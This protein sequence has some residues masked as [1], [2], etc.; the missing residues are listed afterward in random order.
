MTKNVSSFFGKFHWKMYTTTMLIII[1]QIIH[2]VQVVSTDT[3]NDLRCVF[4]VFLF[5][6]YVF[7][8]I[9]I[10]C[11]GLSCLI[12]SIMPLTFLYC[13]LFKYIVVRVS[14]IFFVGIAICCYSDNYYYYMLSAVPQLL[15]FLP[16]MYVCL[17][18]LVVDNI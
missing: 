16:N 10:F 12:H 1:S 5:V 14:L 15:I 11:F 4:D 7:N 13:H 6:L 2:D 18:S 8:F 9:V 17:C 3:V